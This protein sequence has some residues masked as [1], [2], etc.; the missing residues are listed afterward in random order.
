MAFLCRL[1]EVIS[2]LVYRWPDH[3]EQLI[4]LADHQRYLVMVSLGQGVKRLLD[5]YPGH[6]QP[7]GC[8]LQAQSASLL[9]G[10]DDR[11]QPSYLGTCLLQHGTRSGGELPDDLLLLS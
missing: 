10:F 6:V 4:G 2:H 1:I 3:V 9:L 11:D 7:L 8:L 5:L